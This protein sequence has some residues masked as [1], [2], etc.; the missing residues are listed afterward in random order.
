MTCPGFRVRM[1]NGSI[2]SQEF[3]DEMAYLWKK[4]MGVSGGRERTWESD[5]GSGYPIG[6][7]LHQE[8]ES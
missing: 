8:I 4:G 1:M 6:A 2:A 3:F 5:P 7:L